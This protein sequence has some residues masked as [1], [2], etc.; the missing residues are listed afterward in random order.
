MDQIAFENYVGFHFKFRDWSR[1][2][3]GM[4]RIQIEDSF[5]LFNDCLGLPV[6][7]TVDIKLMF[8][9]FMNN[10]LFSLKRSVENLVPL[11]IAQR[12]PMLP[13]QAQNKA[14]QNVISSNNFIS[15]DTQSR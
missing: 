15:W 10:M 13:V 14:L 5:V 3:K 6:T 2:E 7:S 11:N 9:C 4:R 8:V 1:D 12:A